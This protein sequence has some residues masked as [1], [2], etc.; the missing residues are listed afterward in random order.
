MFP[1]SIIAS[2]EELLYEPLTMNLEFENSIEKIQKIEYCVFEKT[3]GSVTIIS[4]A[5]C[6]N[7]IL[8]AT[9]TIEFDGYMNIAFKLTPPGTY[10]YIP[11]IKESTAGRL[12][13]AYLSM[14]LNKK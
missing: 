1:T 4:S 3:E 5:V 9:I 2:G 8:N 7:L 13:K 12:S 11:E 10:C 6:G 14:K